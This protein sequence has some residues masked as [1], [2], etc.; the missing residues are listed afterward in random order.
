MLASL[1]G[2]IINKS[3]VGRS[4]DVSEVTIK[5]Y[6][7]IADGS[8]IWRN[9][10]AFKKSAMKSI[11]KMPKG[12]FRDSGL[13]FF[14]N[15]IHDKDQMLRYS[16]T[17]NLFEA[18]IIEEI[19]RGLN[20]TMLPL[21]QYSYYRTRNGAEVDLVLE[22]S[23]GTLPVEIKFGTD[24]RL[25]KLTSLRRFIDQENLPLGLVI[26]NGADVRVLSDRIV[27]VPARFL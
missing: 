5:E 25:S 1:S 23:F 18:F 7:Q 26:N 12:L 3:D 4:L 6:L 11:V 19:I 21:P 27:Q 2:T 24:T 22:G 13:A 17:G 10:P 20:A 15:N 8:Y 14:L 9:L 16:A